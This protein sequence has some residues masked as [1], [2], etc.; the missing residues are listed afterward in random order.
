MK[1]QCFGC[2]KEADVKDLKRC[3]RCRG[4][5]YCV[6]DALVCRRRAL[7]RAERGLPTQT[8]VCAQGGVR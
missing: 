3:A 7:M 8:L 5:V 4:A 1:N 2:F 6:R